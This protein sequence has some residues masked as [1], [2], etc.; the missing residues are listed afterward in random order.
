[1]IQGKFL[2]V[3]PH[4]YF[5]LS[6][7][8][9]KTFK[10]C[11][12]KY[13]FNYIQ[14][15]PKKEWDFQVFGSF[16][17]ETLE[18]YEKAII[19]QSNEKS[20]I[21]MKKCFSEA[22]KSFPQITPEQKKECFDILTVFL[23]KRQGWNFQPIAAEKD[24]TIDIGNNISLNGFI[25]L[26]KQDEDDIIH[27]VDYKTSKTGDWLKKD[28]LQLKTYAYVMCLENPKLEHVRCSYIMLKL[29][30]EEIKFEFSREQVMSIEQDF[31]DYAADINNE[32]LYRPDTGPLCKYCDYLESCKDG[33][34]WVKAAE[35][36]KNRKEG[37]ITFG[38]TDW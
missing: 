36:R 15:L 29:G 38:A 2:K 22:L 13:Y 26:V 35:E 25:D 21:L 9:A 12:A 17:H 18:R 4:D 33:T 30:F 23:Q 14:K 8:K 20:H 34:K 28:S 31:R 37:K 27:V 5:H 6:V 16:L 7:S 24:F 1:M 3:I 10:Q 11:K 32:K 19:S